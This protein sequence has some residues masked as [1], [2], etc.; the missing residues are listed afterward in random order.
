MWGRHCLD[1]EGK[2][3]Y[4]AGI[5]EMPA[6]YG[7]RCTFHVVARGGIVERC[8]YRWTFKAC[9]ECEHEN[10]IAARYCGACK[11]ELCNPNDKLTLEHS[12][13]KDATVMQTE[14][15]LDVHVTPTLSKA[16][17][18]CLKVKFVTPTRSFLVW[19]NK[20]TPKQT[21]LQVEFELAQNLSIK[22]V[23]YRKESDFYKVYGYNKEVLV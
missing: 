1:L 9:P 8:S 15:C 22:T 3:V 4:I 20:S 11:C 16:G 6:H 13:I 12:R 21:A 5:G 23:C 10:D 14:E 19:F 18:E 2:R 7:R 17:N